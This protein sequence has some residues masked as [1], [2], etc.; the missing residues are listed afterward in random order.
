MRPL[1]RLL[2]ASVAAGGVAGG[3]AVAPPAPARRRRTAEPAATAEFRQQVQPL[4]RQVLRQV[5]QRRRAQGR[6]DAGR[7]SRP[8]GVVDDRQTWEKIAE[9]AARPRNA[10]RGRA[11]ARGRRARQQI[12]RLDRRADWPASTAGSERDPGRVTIRRLIA[13]NTTTRSATWSASTS[14]RPTIFP[15]TTS[16]TAST[17]SATCCRC[18]RS[19]WKSTWPPPKRSS[20]GRW[21]PSRSTW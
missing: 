6:A 13:P 20:S 2:L 10:P 7:L 15:P 5:P 19:C 11:A 21:A 8:R 4:C 16:A 18:R 17:T 12:T 9:E 3:T 1:S 14:I